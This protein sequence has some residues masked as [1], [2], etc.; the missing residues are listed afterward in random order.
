M[1]RETDV[2]IRQLME[3]LLNSE[4]DGSKL[5]VD[6]FKKKNTVEI[7]T[8]LQ[9]VMSLFL[10]LFE[11]LSRQLSQKGMRG[12]VRYSCINWSNVTTRQASEMQFPDT[13]N[14]LL[15][16]ASSGL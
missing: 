16:T 9:Q 6:K 5:D 3:L 13:L 10:H 2:A 8:F 11:S 1:Q 4:V 14:I 15:V 7:H 12:G